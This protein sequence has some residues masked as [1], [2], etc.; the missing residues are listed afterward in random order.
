MFFF[1]SFDFRLLS[2]PKVSCYILWDDVKAKWKRIEKQQ[3][4]Q[5]E[6]E[7]EEEDAQINAI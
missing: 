6:E 4:Y 1:Y 2:K 3:Q 5:H 7:G